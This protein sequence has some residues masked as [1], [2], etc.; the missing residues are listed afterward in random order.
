MIGQL[1]LVSIIIVNTVKLE[2]FYLLLIL[3]LISKVR[4]FQFCWLRRANIGYNSLFR[5]F[6]IPKGRSSEGSLFRRFVIRRVIIPKGRYSEGSLFQRFVIQKG[7]Y[8]EGS[9]T[10]K[11][12]YSEGSNAPKIHYSEDSLARRSV[13]PKV[14]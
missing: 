8:S 2:L 4:T 3:L 7:H 9:N 12:R 10:P 11:I 6:V 13:I 1:G 5:R 14:W